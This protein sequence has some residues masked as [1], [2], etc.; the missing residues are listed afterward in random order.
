MR[1]ILASSLVGKSW[2][3]EHLAQA[4]FFVLIGGSVFSPD[5]F[6]SLRTEVITT[7]D[8]RLI[9]TAKIKRESEVAKFSPS[10]LKDFNIL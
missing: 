5:S 8:Q 10:F 3:P 1:Y 4:L 6:R 2:S 9:F 7:Y